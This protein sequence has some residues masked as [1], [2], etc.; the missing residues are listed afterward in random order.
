MPKFEEQILVWA[1]DAGL[2][3]SSAGSDKAMLSESADCGGRRTEAGLLVKSNI[4]W[5][6]VVAE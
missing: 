5:M 4:L 1:D 2:F 3:G 6:N